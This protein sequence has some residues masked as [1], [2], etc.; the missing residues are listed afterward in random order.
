[1]V[2]SARALDGHPVLRRA[3]L[4]SRGGRGALAP[5]GEAI[6]GVGRQLVESDKVLATSFALL[7]LGKGRRPS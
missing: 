5:A 7:F 3:G 1:M 6:G 2:S 4:V